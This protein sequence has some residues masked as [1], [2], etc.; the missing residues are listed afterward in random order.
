MNES[1][2]ITA[3]TQD[4]LALV[5]P[6]LSTV[7]STALFNLCLSSEVLEN[8]DN[9]VQKRGYKILAKLVEG[10][11]ATFDAKAVLHLLEKNIDGLA[12][13]AKKVGHDPLPLYL[14]KLTFVLDR[15]DSICSIRLFRQSLQRSYIC[16]C[17]LFQKPF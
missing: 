3:V 4:L 17:Q 10:R 1:G 2:S 13:A 7:D 11:K 9:G 8:K 15:T 16:C 6:H 5:L 14:P 12:A